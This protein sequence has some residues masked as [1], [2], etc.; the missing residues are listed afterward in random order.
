MPRNSSLWAPEEQGATYPKK[1]SNLLDTAKSENNR[2]KRY[3]TDH[4]N[5]RP[6]KKLKTKETRNFAF[7]SL[8]L[9]TEL[10]SFSEGEGH[11]T[12]NRLDV[13]IKDYHGRTLTATFRGIYRLDPPAQSNEVK[14]ESRHF[15]NN[16][17]VSIY[18]HERNGV[19]YL[20]ETKNKIRVLT[21]NARPMRIQHISSSFRSH[22]NLFVLDNSTTAS[23][24]QAGSLTSQQALAVSDIV[25]R[26]W[27]EQY[28]MRRLIIHILGPDP[29]HSLLADEI[30]TRLQ[31]A[32]YRDLTLL[33]NVHMDTRGMRHHF[34]AHATPTTTPMP[35]AQAELFPPI[36]LTGNVIVEEGQGGREREEVRVMSNLNFNPNRNVTQNV[37]RNV[38]QNLSQNETRNA[39]RN[40]SRHVS[41]LR[42]QLQPPLEPA[43]QPP[44]EPNQSQAQTGSQTQTQTQTQTQSQT[45]SA[46]N[47]SQEGGRGDR[48]P[49]SILEIL[50]RSN[51][52]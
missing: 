17:K 10:F 39:S 35:R 40:A 45:Q 46:L 25:R 18:V 52:V 1:L 27:L 9:N 8:R 47:P 34:R 42:L 26:V 37:S 30:M 5:S 50:G 20:V 23:A 48:R 32:G 41:Q 14:L 24:I 22:F 43:H 29:F 2:V 49:E 15:S 51:P 44:D 6:R 16:V 13:M 31:A 19:Q 7:P 21:E 11:Y 28:R 12:G 38:S 36:E 33:Q 3:Q 4:Q